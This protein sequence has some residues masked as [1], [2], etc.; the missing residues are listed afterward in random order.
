M[1]LHNLN[2]VL[3]SLGPVEVRYYGLVYVL[4]FIFAMWIIPRL[5]KKHG[6]KS[7]D[8]ETVNDFIFWTIIGSIITARLFATLV[9]NPGYFF[10]HPLDILKIWQ[11]GMSFHG[12]LLG[13]V[14]V[15]FVFGKIKKIKFYDIADLAIIPFTVTLIFGRIANFINAEL[16][17]KPSSL[18]WCVVFRE[19]DVCRHPS[20]I[21]EAFKNVVI[22]TGLL[23]LNSR[24]RVPG[25]V[26]WSFV[27]MYGVLR[28]LVEFVR[29]GDVIFL[30][31]TMGQLLSLPMIISA[32]VLLIRLHKD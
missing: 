1:I 32:I 26:F 30:G 18:P 29:A 22:T 23:I 27:L 25:R 14:I 31:M 4:G 6:I 16:I 24:K 12:G 21:Y 3:L 20:Q 10:F 7:L 19:G 2:P 9:Y 13:A 11:G 8:Q 28:F 5:A 15:A 17:G